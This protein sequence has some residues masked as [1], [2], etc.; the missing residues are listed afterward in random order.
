MNKHEQQ[1]QISKHETEDTI[2]ADKWI[3]ASGLDASSFSSTHIR[4]LQAQQ[5]ASS[6][7]KNHSNLITNLERRTIEN[8]QKQMA[9][10]KT[11]TKLKP[12]VA[13]PILCIYNRINRQL[14]KKQKKIIQE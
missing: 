4:L 2:T 13:N 12:Q 6:I 7:L 1:Y 10:K 8:F 11:R 5:K 9:H 3:A 14:F